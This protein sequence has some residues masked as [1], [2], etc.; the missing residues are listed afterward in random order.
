MVASAS[1]SFYPKIIKLKILK[2]CCIYV[3]A[4][5]TKQKFINALCCSDYCII[6]YNNIYFHSVRNLLYGFVYSLE[7]NK[8]ISMNQ[9]QQKLGRESR[10][11][12][13]LYLSKTARSLKRKCLQKERLIEDLTIGMVFTPYCKFI[14]SKALKIPFSHVIKKKSELI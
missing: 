11:G 7:Q 12:K 2:T 6:Y 1:K 10:K 14:T 9:F 8:N 5:D 3:N 13:Y 4:S